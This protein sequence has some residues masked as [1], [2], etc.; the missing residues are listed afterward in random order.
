MKY[1]VNR[2]VGE[3]SKKTYLE[4]IQS[5]FF[6]KYMSGPK[7]I[8]LGYAGYIPD[9]VPILDT[10]IGVDL[11]TP[12]YDGHTL[13]FDDN[14]LDYVYS[15]HFLEHVSDYKN[16]LK[17]MFRVLKHECHIVLTVPHKFLY[18]KKE[19]LPSRFNEDHKRFYTPASLLT[20]VEESLVHNSY[21][22]RHLQD[23]DKG[24]VYTDLPEVHGKWLYEIELVIQKL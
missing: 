21:R 19:S 22:I 11:N 6:H 20:E 17:E 1:D 18:E 9:V 13:P 14:S 8:D 2:R 7:G 5:G 4:K 23:N 24:H 3:E 15:S 12:G 10:A 16:M